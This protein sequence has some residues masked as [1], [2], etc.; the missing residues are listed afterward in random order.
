MIM[1]LVRTSIFLVILFCF[2]GCAISPKYTVA[3]SESDVR[4]GISVDSGYPGCPDCS[5]VM[6][7]TSSALTGYYWMYNESVNDKGQLT[8][9]IHVGVTNNQPNHSNSYFL[10]VDQTNSGVFIYGA[11]VYLVDDAGNKKQLTSAQMNGYDLDRPKKC[12]NS[13]GQ[14]CWWTDYFWLPNATLNQIINS[15]KPL[16]LFIGQDRNVAATDGFNRT[17]QSVTVGVPV[18]LSNEYLKIFKNELSV[19]GVQ[20]P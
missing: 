16:T 20:L 10:K 15:G 11:T 12:S 6:T 4:E 7:Y 13:V 14:S 5:K 3:Q 9:R 1:H 19:R 8:G 2:S 18:N 17:V